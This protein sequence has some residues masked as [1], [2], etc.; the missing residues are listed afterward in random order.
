LL[1]E[2]L[3]SVPKFA[4]PYNT[5][6]TWYVSGHLVLGGSGQLFSGNLHM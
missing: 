5:Y 2:V 1:Q 3:K 6:Q 4:F